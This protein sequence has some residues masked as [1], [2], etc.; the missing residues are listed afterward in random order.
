MTE[1]LWEAGLHIM[2]SST[3]RGMKTFYPQS[4]EPYAP[5]MNAIPKAYFSRSGAN[6]ALAAK[7][8]DD[9]KR[10]SPR[11]VPE[12]A[13]RVLSRELK[14]LTQMGV[15]RRIDHKQVPPK[16]EYE[17]T[18]WRQPDPHDQGDP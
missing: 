10:P 16:V 14:T 11:G 3:F 13:V 4:A 15:V 18:G 8:L 1:R 6:D 5:P 12:I 17:L 2:G 9:A 7:S